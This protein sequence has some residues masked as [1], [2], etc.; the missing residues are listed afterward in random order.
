MRHGTKNNSAT[1]PIFIPEG[2][3]IEIV[4]ASDGAHLL[5]MQL[6]ACLTGDTR[7]VTDRGV[8]TISDLSGKHINVKQYNYL[9]NTFTYTV[10]DVVQTKLATELISIELEDGTVIKGTPE[11]RIMLADGIYKMLKDLT[12]DD[13]IMTPNNVTEVIE[14]V[15]LKLSQNW[16]GF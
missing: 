2:N 14:S 8:Y 6:W 1:K 13:D 4:A 3:Q 12:E 16:G 10:A 7:I 5:G 9:N 15:K 11:H